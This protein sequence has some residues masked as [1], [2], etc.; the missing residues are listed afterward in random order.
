MVS[1]RHTETGLLQPPYFFDV[2][3]FKVQV[4]KG[5]ILPVSFFLDAVNFDETV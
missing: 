4:R 5:I 1:V 2:L 3:M